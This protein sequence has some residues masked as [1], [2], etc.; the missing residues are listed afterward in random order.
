MTSKAC[1]VDLFI[2]HLKVECGA[3]AQQHEVP[4]IFFIFIGVLII[5]FAPLFVFCLSAISSKNF[6]IKSELVRILVGMSEQV[7]RV[8]DVIATICVSNFSAL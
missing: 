3:P 5:Y 6:Q 8:R 1:E 2:V 7:G 4:V